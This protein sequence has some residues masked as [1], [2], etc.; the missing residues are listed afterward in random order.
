MVGDLFWPGADRAEGVFSQ[1]GFLDAIIAV[2]AAWLAALVEHEVAPP[3]AAD[4][5]VDLVSD[6][7]LEWLTNES[8][9]TGNPAV[10]LVDLLR[11]GVAPRNAA[12]AA[13]LHRGLTSQDVVDTA[14]MICARDA[15]RALLDHLDGVIDALVHLASDH[16]DTLM[17]GRTLT[18]HAVPIT[19]GLKAARWLTGVLDAADDL[20]AL[21]L[22]IQLGGAAGTLAAV[23]ELAGA[24]RAGALVEATAERLGLEPSAPWHTTRSPITRFGDALVRTT[25]ACGHLAN[26]VLTLSRPEIGEVTE[27]TGGGSSTMPGKTNPV[28]SLQIS[29]AALTTPALAATLHVAAAAQVDERAGGPWHAEWATLRTLVR[30]SVVAVAQ[31]GELLSGLQVHRDR[32][33]A[34]LDGARQAVLAEQDVMARLA[35]QDPGADYFGLCGEQVDV[36]IARARARAEVSS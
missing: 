34:T 19:F 5:L 16:R 31:T 33:L 30:R 28:L 6:H 25:D 15:V 35:G 14:L 7:H 12:A 4:G 24:D 10:G 27:G 2:E 21:H 11:D 18:Q 1:A 36:V 3:S 20:A 8:E 32:M 23:V 13:W 17:V 22:P 29:R 9:L 26:D